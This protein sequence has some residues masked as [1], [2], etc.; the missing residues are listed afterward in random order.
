MRHYRLTFEHSGYSV[1]C[2]LTTDHPASHYGQP[3]YVD[4]DGIAH[5]QQGLEHLVPWIK[6]EA[7]PITST[8]IR[9]KHGCSRCTWWQRKGSSG[10]GQCVSGMRDRP[11]YACG[12][13]VEY[14]MMFVDDTIE[15]DT[16]DLL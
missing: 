15:I 7:F 6:F 16:E 2:H 11:Y 1:V 3:V 9:P 10:Y 4:D 12:P 13:C 5:A 14:E 8:V